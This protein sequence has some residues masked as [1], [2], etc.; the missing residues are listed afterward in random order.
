MPTSKKVKSFAEKLEDLNKDLKTVKDLRD[1]A[2]K[3]TKEA[4]DKERAANKKRFEILSTE[5]KLWNIDP[6]DLQFIVDACKF[7]KDFLAENEPSLVDTDK[8][9]SMKDGSD[10]NG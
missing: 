4:N 5:L 2:N 6:N 10:S 8:D 7:Y 1:E 9:V 3:K